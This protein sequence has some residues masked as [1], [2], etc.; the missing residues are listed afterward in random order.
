M[1]TDQKK[2]VASSYFFMTED[3][4][5]E[6]SNPLSWKQQN[7]TEQLRVLATIAHCI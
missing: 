1:A 4:L 6:V 5:S 3:V 7:I 2:V